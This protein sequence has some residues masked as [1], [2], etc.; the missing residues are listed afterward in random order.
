MFYTY[1][2]IYAAILVIVCTLG[3]K[4]FWRRTV[5]EPWET[6]LLVTV[7]ILTVVWGVALGYN[8][9]PF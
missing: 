4:G 1:T 9:I 5:G 3:V 6:M 8:I 2:I 7:C